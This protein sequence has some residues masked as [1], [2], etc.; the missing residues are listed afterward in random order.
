MLSLSATPIPRTLHMSL[1]G[2]RDI[3]VIE[4]PPA[5]R[6]ADP[7][8]RRRVRRGAARSR[9]HTRGGARRP[10]V[11]PAQP[12]RDDRRGREHLR[13]LLPGLRFLVVHGQMPERELEKRMLSFLAGDADVLVST[14]IIESGWTSRRRTRSWSSAPDTLGLAQLYQIRGRVGRSDVPA[15]AYLFY[16]DG[17]ELTTEARARLATLA[18]HTELGAGFCDRDARPRD[19][20]RR[21]SPRG[22]AVRTRCRRR[23]RALRRAPRG[24][25]GRAERSASCRGDAARASGRSHRRVR[26]VRVRSLEAQKIDLHR[27]LALAESEDEL[28]ELRA[29]AED[30]YGPLPDPVEHLFAIQEAKL[31]LARLGGD[32]LVYRGGKA[33][34]GP[35]VLGSEEFAS[36]GVAPRPRCTRARSARCRFAATGSREPSVCSLL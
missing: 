30:R 7:H 8:A 36:C 11:L 18:D 22:R 17:H 24:S 27:R 5:G 9:A 28:R 6:A 19:Q 21:R 20:G 4:T 1:A 29:A 10:V 35:L 12:R 32:Y 2:L 14:T 23:V 33:T 3:S 15:H 25:G 13:Q 34:V 26:A 31:M 16:P